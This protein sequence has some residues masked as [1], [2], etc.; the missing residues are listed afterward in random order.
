MTPISKLSGR[1]TDRLVSPPTPCATL[2][3]LPTRRFKFYKA[4][5]CTSY[6][7]PN[8]ATSDVAFLEADKDDDRPQFVISLNGK[9]MR[10]LLDT[11]ASRTTL[12][13]KAAEALGITE[14]SGRL[15][16]SQFAVGVGA[17]RSQRWKTK[18]DQIAIG[19]IIWHDKEI[20][21]G[22]LAGSDEKSPEIILG[23][24]FLLEH[25]VLFSMGS[26]RLFLAQFKN[27]L[28]G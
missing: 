15:Q 19:N 24:D 28:N 8:W 17:G 2:D 18:I 9:A 23:K 16:T 26:R 10:A 20:S 11:A 13:L 22:S 12:S 3:G 4:K 1:V 5:E 7:K 25:R 6:P 14:A 27:V 21:V